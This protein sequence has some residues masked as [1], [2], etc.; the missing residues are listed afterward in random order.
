MVNS[1]IIAT[2]LAS[3][4]LR[5]D[6]SIITNP[7]SASPTFQPQLSSSS[8]SFSSSSTSLAAQLQ[9]SQPTLKVQTNQHGIPNLDVIGHQLQGPHGLLVKTKK[10]RKNQKI[11]KPTSSTLVLYVVDLYDHG[12]ESSNQSHQPKS[13]LVY[14]LIGNSSSNIP[15]IVE[16][17]SLFNI[18]SN[19]NVQLRSQKLTLDQ[20][21]RSRFE[22][23]HRSSSSLSSSSSS[24]QQSNPELT[25]I[26]LDTVKIENLGF[27][28]DQKLDDDADPDEEALEQEMA[29]YDANQ[30]KI[31]G[32]IR[33]AGSISKVILWHFLCH[34]YQEVFL[35]PQAN[36]ITP[37]AWVYVRLTRNRR[38]IVKD[39]RIGG[40]AVVRDLL[41]RS[42]MGKP[43]I[44][45]QIGFQR[46]HCTRFEIRKV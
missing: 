10:K 22:N 1:G 29:N 5:T 9:R 21:G 41:T 8:S 34:N 4:S 2:S 11:Q 23:Q 16:L 30:E 13:Q 19:R 6:R 38:A 46:C 20:E 27:E 12:Q 26:R 33:E 35:G 39:V 14:W 32:S 42:A 28:D 7:S 18:L 37:T 40:T 36:F 31:G 15:Q 25:Q 17:Q 24:H 45:L 3:T 43:M 44:L